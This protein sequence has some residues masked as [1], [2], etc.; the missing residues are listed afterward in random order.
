[1]VCFQTNG[2]HKADK[3]VDM[4][5]LGLQI[6]FEPNQNF[7]FLVQ[8]RFRV[9]FSSAVFLKNYSVFGSVSIFK[10]PE[11]NQIFKKSYTKF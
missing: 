11:N 7:Q 9:W 3:E 2:K 4:L 6:L 10:K 1:M 5:K 8:L